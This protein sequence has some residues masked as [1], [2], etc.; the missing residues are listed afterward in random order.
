[1]KKRQNLI[2]ALFGAALVCLAV[3]IG[4]VALP[5]FVTAAPA[6]GVAWR[7]EEEE[8]TINVYK[9][10]KDVVVFIS[11]VTLTI[12]P[13]DWFSE[14]Q[15]QKGTGSGIVI[16]AEKGI[17]VTNLHVVQG[18][19]GIEI[20]LGNGQPAEARLLGYDQEYDIALLQLNNPPKNLT[21]LVFGDSSK[22]EVGQRV[23]AIGNPFGL[24]RTLT[25]GIISSL[26]RTVKS[27]TGVV[28]KGLIQTDA[29]INPGNS[30]GPLL[31]SEGRLIGIN[32]AILSQSGDSAGIGFAVPIN[33]IRRILPEL[34]ATGKVLR[35][36]MG[37]VL[38]DTTAGVMVRRV[39]PGGPADKAGIQPIE[40]AVEDVFLRGYVRDFDRADL[41]YAVNGQRVLSKDQVEELVAS[42]APRKTLE[43]TLR[44]GGTEG[45]ER[46]ASIQAVLR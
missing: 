28:M 36:N 12:D 7:T 21:S 24:N 11:T 5:K 33:P 38:V 13:T 15:P 3:L 31:D 22:L 29:A 43:L 37:W 9:R 46:T 23:L 42:S 18:A 1:M 45:P 17:I 6:A 41:I 39:M 8:H 35:P 40:R 30:G 32:T 19:Q 16:D 20:L 4:S 44:R 34:I 10:A 14:I 27:P 25:S 26:D 2:I